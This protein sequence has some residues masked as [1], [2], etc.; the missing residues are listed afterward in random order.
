MLRFVC[1]FVMFLSTRIWPRLAVITCNFNR[2]LKLQSEIRGEKSTDSG[3]SI[4]SNKAYVGGSVVSS[5][6]FNLDLTH[7]QVAVN[8]LPL[9]ASRRIDDENNVCAI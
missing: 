1:R 3:T 7:A 4:G 6:Q 9:L 2:K 8:I 5:F